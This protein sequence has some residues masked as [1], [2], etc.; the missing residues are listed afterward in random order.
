[1]SSLLSQTG[2]LPWVELPY[3]DEL[4]HKHSRVEAA[5][6]HGRIAAPVAPVVAS[7]LRTGARARISLH[8]GPGRRLGFF[9]P[10]TH[11]FVDPIADG[12]LSLLARPELVAAAEGLVGRPDLPE[13]LELRSDGSRVVLVADCRLPAG[14]WGVEA[15]SGRDQNHGNIHLF[16]DNLRV[17]PRSFYQVNLEVNRLVVAAVQAELRDSGAERLLDLY[18]GIGNLSV[19]AIRGGLPA[20]LVEEDRSSL[21][22][23]RYNTD[24]RA[25]VQGAAEVVRLDLRRYEAGRWPFDVAVL[26]PP[27]SGA[28]GL[29]PK[30]ALTRPRTVIY[31]SCD[32]ITLAR[33]VATL[34]PAGYRIQKVQPFDMFPGADHIETLMVLRRGD[35]APD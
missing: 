3:A 15:A 4:A 33:D 24:R 28:T 34:L 18:A 23:A 12:S 27:R 13:S 30:L 35:L 9:R 8:R 21:G 31:L 25:G 14:A 29:L 16:I 17:S 5:L 1:M 26:D 6:R 19:P 22:D 2:I 7:P 10:G 11:D 32:P 20:V